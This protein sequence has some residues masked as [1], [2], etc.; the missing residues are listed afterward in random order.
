VACTLLEEEEEE[1]EERTFE[2]P[3]SEMEYRS[4]GSQHGTSCTLCMYDVLLCSTSIQIVP[5]IF[6]S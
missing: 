2:V 4:A 5:L 3:G 1:E 6:H